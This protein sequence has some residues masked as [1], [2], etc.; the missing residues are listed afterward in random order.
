MPKQTPLI[1]QG[2][3]T[4][5]WYIVTKYKQLKGDKIQALEKFDVTDRV[6]EIVSNTIKGLQ[7]V[8]QSA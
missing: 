3:L 6:L 8:D 7:E 2:C 1:M 4:G 5:K